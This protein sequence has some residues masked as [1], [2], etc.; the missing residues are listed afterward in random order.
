MTTDKGIDWPLLMR[1][2][3]NGLG[4]APDAFWQLTPAELQLMIGPNHTRAPLFN[5]GLAE[6][7]AAY[8]DTTKGNFDAG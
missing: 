8:P 2:G 6:L 4:M 3:L 1:A 7:M 5:D